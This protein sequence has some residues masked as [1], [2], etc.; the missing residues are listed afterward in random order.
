[1]DILLVLGN[2]VTKK[3]YA[4]VSHAMLERGLKPKVV[5][6]STELSTESDFI[7]RLVS[8]DEI[9]K[10]SLKEI[11]DLV[12]S[13]SDVLKTQIIRESFGE[14]SF[15]DVKAVVREPFGDDE[16][17]ETKMLWLTSQ[18]TPSYCEYT[19]II[20]NDGNPWLQGEGYGDLNIPQTA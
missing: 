3:H 4:P 16:D 17:H 20:G 19:V 12:D 8:F 10:L 6:V 9:D 11:G 13:R 15:D 7:D 14:L 18:I 2:A 5:R 1:M